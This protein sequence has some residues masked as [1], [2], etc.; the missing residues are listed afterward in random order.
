[1]KVYHQPYSE[2]KKIPLR[3]AIFLDAAETAIQDYTKQEYKK[4]KREAEKKL[5]GY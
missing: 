3:T 1:M 2:I 5:K 4:Q